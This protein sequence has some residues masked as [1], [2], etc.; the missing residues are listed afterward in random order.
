MSEPRVAV[1]GAGV[2]GLACA[3]E[4]RR[5]GAEVVVLER[6]RVGT[7]VSR[8]NTGWV[9]PSLTYPLP[10]PGMLREG[11]RQLF[12]G[13]DAFVLRP[14]LDP[15]S[16]AWLWSFRRSCS[17]ARFDRGI[18]ALLALN[19]RTLELFDA[20]REAGVAFEMHAAGLVVAARTTGGLDLYRRTFRR[21]RELG[22]EGGA[23]DELDA[24]GLVA[25]EPALDRSRVVAGLHA[26][27]DRFVRPEQLT[28]GLADRL[29]A[30]GVEIRE[31]CELRTL[32][33]TT[34]GW[35]LE[36]SSGPLAAGR[37]V[38]AAGL[39]TAPL[40][41]R[42][43]VRLPLLGARGY[44]VTI[45]GRGT[46]PRHALYL[47]EAKLGLSP[48]EAG[49]RIAGVFELGASNADISP[50]V[51]ER[52]LSAARPYLAGWRPDPDGTVEAWAGLR[53]ATPDGLPL[54]GAV[55]GVD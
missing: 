42:L 20:Y 16:L 17:N 40:L 5:R 35:A 31:G 23:I 6:A 53:P 28:V 15:A 45:P 10:G 14:R 7:G 49:V 18:R 8:G 12:T 38:V 13:G 19:R 30:D 1:V 3:W 43:G 27:V 39:P 37:L 22:Y 11:V 48:F 29:R 47:A 21:L 34:G 52:L 55:P 9:S 2:V 51:G 25:L 33:R 32:A 54:I 41:R 50:A 46:P 44:S 36:T 4:L 24:E 26:H